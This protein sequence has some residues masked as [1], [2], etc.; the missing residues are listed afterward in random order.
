[1]ILLYFQKLLLF[2][3]FFYFHNILTNTHS[4]LSLHIPHGHIH[5]LFN[6]YNDKEKILIASKTIVF[7][8]FSMI[9]KMKDHLTNIAVL[10]NLQRTWKNRDWLCN[11]DIKVSVR[12]Q[13]LKVVI[14]PTGWFFLNLKKLKIYCK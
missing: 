1:M 5:Y 12:L 7:G 14:F 6:I 9:P 10:F 8:T 4:I 2:K 13:R 11:G 3:F